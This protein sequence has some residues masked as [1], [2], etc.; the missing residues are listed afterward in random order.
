MSKMLLDRFV[1]FLL[2]SQKYTKTDMLY[3]AHGGSY[4]L[5]QIRRWRRAP[6]LPP[7]A[8]E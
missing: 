8:F 3:L 4:L 5:E 1:R 7:S 2:W 6:A